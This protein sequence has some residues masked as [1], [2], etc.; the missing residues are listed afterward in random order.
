MLGLLVNDNFF[1]TDFLT[2]QSVFGAEEVIKNK[3]VEVNPR[4]AVQT[5]DD[6]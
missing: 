4:R 3:A 1:E 6:V 5:V 2:V